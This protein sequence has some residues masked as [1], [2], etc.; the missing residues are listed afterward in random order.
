MQWGDKL[1]PAG[2]DM[3]A[4]VLGKMTAIKMLSLVMSCDE[5]EAF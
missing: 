2:V 4:V 5:T 3:L 1:G